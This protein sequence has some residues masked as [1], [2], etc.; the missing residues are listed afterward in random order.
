M[1]Y[2]LKTKILLILS[3]ANIKYQRIKANGHTFWRQLA[4]LGKG[5]TRKKERDLLFL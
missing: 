4:V 3:T 5:D 2:Y 1:E